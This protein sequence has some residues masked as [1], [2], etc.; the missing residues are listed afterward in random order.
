VNADRV[1]LRLKKSN[2]AAATAPN[3][4][5][6][7]LTVAEAAA[8]LR[9]S[10]VTLC[11]WRIEGHGPT[12][13]KFGRRVVYAREELDAWASNQRRCSTSEEAQ[14]RAKGVNMNSG[15]IGGSVEGATD[16]ALQQSQRSC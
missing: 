16:D 15:A 7:F 1:R 3:A 10:T 12:F 8:L 5:A 6:M 11:R 13:R 2:A 4:Q 9:V 14:S